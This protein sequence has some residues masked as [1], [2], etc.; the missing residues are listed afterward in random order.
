MAL[1][2]VPI[3]ILYRTQISYSPPEGRT[4]PLS[5]PYLTARP[6]L[7]TNPIPSRKSLFPKTR[8]HLL[9]PTPPSLP[10]FSPLFSLFLPLPST[11]LLISQKTKNKKHPPFSAYIGRRLKI[12]P[13]LTC[14]GMNE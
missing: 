2:Y 8:T 10:P 3:E 4:P 1:P 6:T 13:F 11:P 14:W 9:T 7:D 12:Y 5:P